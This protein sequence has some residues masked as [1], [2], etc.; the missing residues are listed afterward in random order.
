MPDTLPSAFPLAFW[1]ALAFGFAVILLYSITEFTRPTSPPL[2]SWPEHPFSVSD[3]TTRRDYLVSYLLYLAGLEFVFILFCLIG[4]APFIGL[5]P[6]SLF[7]PML[8]EQELHKYSDASTF[9]LLFSLTLVGLVPRIPFLQSIELQ[10]RRLLHERAAI[11]GAAV[12]LSEKMRDSPIDIDSVRDNLIPNMDSMR[13]NNIEKYLNC[14]PGSVEYSWARFSMLANI[15][16][17]LCSLNY[18][19][20]HS[21]LRRHISEKFLQKYKNESFEVGD[22]YQRLQD[23]LVSLEDQSEIPDVN[24]A[25][26][27]LTQS[28][29]E[30]NSSFNKCCILLSCA[31]V[32]K[33]HKSGSNAE[34]FMALGLKADDSDFENTEYRR[35]KADIDIVAQAVGLAL[36]LSCLAAIYAHLAKAVP[37]FPSS[38]WCAS[39][40][41]DV[42]PFNGFSM[43]GALLMVHGGAI[44]TA[45]LYRLHLIRRSRWFTGED[46]K[47]GSPTF[48]KYL[49]VCT[50]GAEVAFP[51]TI[52]WDTLF[53]LRRTN[54]EP[55]GQGEPKINSTKDADQECKAETGELVG[56]S[57]ESEYLQEG[58]LTDATRHVAEQSELLAQLLERFY[59]TGPFVLVGGCMAYFVIR[60]LDMTVL[61]GGAKRLYRLVMVQLPVIGIVQWVA[62]YHYFGDRAKTG[63]GAVWYSTIAVMIFSTTLM[64]W[65]AWRK[66]S[67][68]LEGVEDERPSKAST[69]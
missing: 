18:N 50:A 43:F 54:I 38:W 52:Y 26:S 65:L 51:L 41:Q 6:I 42:E 13:T 48:L 32:A 45:F 63:I 11:P 57:G 8:F 40:P 10:W 66:S 16:T 28:R 37:G 55:S 21:V 14:P 12:R 46:K 31:I 19:L 64:L 47:Y 67:A 17:N 22:V 58:L 59:H 3:L 30:I 69:S 53:K 15:I 49:L 2:P 35:S 29:E 68:L 7:N 27:F 23:R 62:C 36:A 56:D 1:A 60:L 24:E 44:S 33:R 61:P 9:P 5:N 20:Q 4:P 25:R 34:A 39:W